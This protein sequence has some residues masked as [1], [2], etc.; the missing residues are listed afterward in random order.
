MDPEITCPQRNRERGPDSSGHLLALVFALSP[1]AIATK[2]PLETI[3]SCL[4]V[5]MA[6]ENELKR[7]V[8]R[9]EPGS[10]KRIHVAGALR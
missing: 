5:V 3:S 9:R 6:D 1:A 8:S 7:T 2:R 10:A 4:S